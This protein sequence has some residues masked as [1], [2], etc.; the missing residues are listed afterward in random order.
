MIISLTGFMGSGK[1]SVGVR[2]ATCLGYEFI[3]LDYYIEKKIG[4]SIDEIFKEQGED[5]FRAI[6]ALRDV[7]IMHKLTAENL[8]LALGGGTLSIGGVTHLIF[9][10][11]T[12]VYLKANEETLKRRIEKSDNKIRPLWDTETLSQLYKSRKDLYESAPICVETDDLSEEEVAEKVA[13][14]IKKE[15]SI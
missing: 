14:L 9:E 13:K 7:V 11:T 15:H 6:E 3:D 10:D 2:L 5:G 8:V 12:C 4:L 1:S